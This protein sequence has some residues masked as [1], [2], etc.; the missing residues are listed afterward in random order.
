[1]LTK[2]KFTNKIKKQTNEEEVKLCND[3][4]RI[5]NSVSRADAVTDKWTS[6]GNVKNNCLVA[7]TL[8]Q[9]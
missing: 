1:M 2:N 7:K 8:S 9:R 4:Q 5:R 6:E 3:L